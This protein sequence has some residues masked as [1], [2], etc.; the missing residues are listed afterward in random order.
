MKHWIFFTMVSASVALA[1][2]SQAAPSTR[3]A[4]TEFGALGTFS[5][6]CL[7]DIERESGRRIILQAP[8]FGTPTLEWLF[9]VFEN[10]GTKKLSIDIT[11]NITSAKMV[12]ENK[13]RMD[14]E[15]ASQTAVENGKESNIN[16]FENDKKFTFPVV[17]NGE[18]VNMVVMQ[19]MMDVEKCLD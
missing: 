4:L 3:E 14:V 15:V 9:V 8:I 5:T 19:K 2:P 17:K 7:Q 16:L 12:T 1:S 11:F 10:N 6:D 13:L 18:K